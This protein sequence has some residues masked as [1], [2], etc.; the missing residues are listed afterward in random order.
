MQS[1]PTSLD[2]SKYV[3]TFSKRDTQGLNPKNQQWYLESCELAGELDG[4][5]PNALPNFSTDRKVKYSFMDMR[6]KVTHSRELTIPNGSHKSPSQ[7]C[8]YMTDH[9]LHM[10]RNSKFP[11]TNIR[12]DSI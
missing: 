10:C 1:E 12:I 2:S 3:I 6:T 5:I 4:A 8:D 11:M 7:V 9:L